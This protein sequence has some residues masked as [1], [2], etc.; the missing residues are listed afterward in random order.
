MITIG[1]AAGHVK[2]PA[3]IERLLRVPPD[4]LS[5]ITL[6][7]YTLEPKDGNPGNSFWADGE[8]RPTS[9]NSLGLPNPG[10][11]AMEDHFWIMG[12]QIRASGKR[13]RVSIAGFSPREYK[14]MAQMA[15]GARPFELELNLGCPNVWKDGQQKRITSFDLDLIRET[16]LQVS[17][18]TDNA[19]APAVAVKLSVYSDPFLLEEVARLLSDMRHIVQSVVV[20]NTFPN[21]S[22]FDSGG[23]LLIDAT[24]GYGGLAGNSLKYIALGQ[25]R[26]FRHLLSSTIDV[27]G[28]GGISTGQDVLDMERAGASSVQ[29]G[30][31]YFMH[32]DPSIFV[33]IMRQYA[34]LSEA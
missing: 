8:T 2:R 18:V 17:E 1:V 20:C 3:D 24:D 28:V 12:E 7:S 19:D 10:M 14:L 5:S 27:V 31:A 13:V 30:T 22:G 9:I 23:K 4:V 16:L 11:S 33:D 15:M 29:I 34:E 32:G 21:G 6:G 25:V 26:K